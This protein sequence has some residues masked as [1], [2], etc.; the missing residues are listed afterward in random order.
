MAVAGGYAYVA[1][2]ERGLRV[3]N[4]ANPTAPTE[5]GFRQTFR[6]MAV[7]VANG[8]AYLADEFNGLRVIRVTNPAV[9]VEISA[10]S[11]LNAYDVMV[12]AGYAYVAYGNAAWVS[13][14]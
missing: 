3:I 5:V 7:A 8:Y 1:D 14:T 10:V 6:A 2:Q 11:G 4:V 9:P 12:M 13:S